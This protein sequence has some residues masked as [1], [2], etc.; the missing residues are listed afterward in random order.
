MRAPRTL[1]AALGLTLAA[2]AAK[3]Q[4]AIE[5]VAGGGPG[6]GSPALLVN[7]RTPQDVVRDAV[8]NT[9]I[10]VSDD[11]RVYRIG[12]DGNIALV[13]GSGGAG[14]SGDGGPAVKA[15]LVS[16]KGLAFDTDGSLLIA[17]EGGRRVR[18]V[19]LASGKISTLVGGGSLTGE[20][21]A[22]LQIALDA[23]RDVAVAPGGNLFLAD[24]HRVRKLDRITGLVTTV[25][26][27]GT[28]GFSD[29]SPAASRRLNEPRALAI[30]SSGA[31]LIADGGNGR[32]RKLVLGTDTISTLVSGICSPGGVAVDAA[33]VYFNSNT[34][35]CG[36][37]AQKYQKWASGSV[38]TITSTG[39]NFVAQMSV[40]AGGTLLVADRDNYRMKSVS[41]S[42]VVTNLAGN[43]TIGTYGGVPALS[44]SMLSP[45]HVRADA[46]GNIYVYD[47][48][49]QIRRVNPAGIE[50]TLASAVNCGSDPKAFLCA[51]EGLAMLPGGSL[52]ISDSK[53]DKLRKI[54]PA[55][56]VVTD[57]TTATL[58]RPRGI[59]SSASGFVY[60][61]DRGNGN[62][63]GAI[64]K[65][66]ATTGVMTVVAASLPRPQYVAVDGAD[67]VYFTS[68][69]GS[70][71]LRILAGGSSASTYVTLTS[72][73]TGL[74]ADAAGNVFASDS[75]NQVWKIA[76][77]TSSL[78]AGSGGQGLGD[79][80]SALDASLS[81]P[82]GLSVVGTDLYIA[83]ALN[84]R[85]RRVRANRAPTAAAGSDQTLEATSPSGAA[86]V[87]DGTASTD[88][89]GDALAFSWSGPFGSASGSTASITLPLGTHTIT[90]SVSDGLMSAVDTLSVTVQD[91]VGPHIS[92]VRSPLPNANGWNNSDVTL[93]FTCS[94]SG[95][96]AM[97]AGPPA[98]DV[99]A[100]EGAGQ[101][102]TFECSDAAGNH[103]SF[104][105][106]NINIDKTAP[107]AT[108]SA[109]PA[110][111]AA[112]WN[113]GD[114]TAS[115]TGA[116]ALSGLDG[117]QGNLVFTAEGAGQSTTGT[118]I[119]RAGNVSLP[120]VVGPIN[121]DK[122]T[123]TASA[124]RS[125]AA[126]AHGWNNTDVTVTFEGLDALSGIASCTSPAL[127][128]AEGAGQAASGTCVDVAGN[129]S[130]SASM[131][132][133][134]ID[135][136]APSISGERS[137]LANVHGWNN[138]DVT[139]SFGATDGL[140]G[141]DSC[142]PAVVLSSEAA[143]QSATGSCLDLAGN[144][145]SATVSDI[146]I[147]KTAPSSSATRSPAANA[148]GWNNTDVT[149]SFGSTD[150]LSGLD[151]CDPAVVLSGEAAGQSASG[152]CIDLAGNAASA[153]V[154][155]INIDKTTP[156]VSFGAAS[157]AANANG[158]NNTDV[159][160]G[161]SASDNLS[162]VD[163]TSVPSP[164]VLSS[165]GD[166]VSVSVEVTDLA[167]NTA[168][169][170]TPVV[171]IDKTAPEATGARVPLANVHG[172]NNSDVTVSVSAIDAL[173]GVESCEPDVVLSAEGASQS[174][175]LTCLDLAGNSASATV[176]DIN[177]D[178]TAPSSSATRSP[179]ANAHGWNNTDV[180]VAFEASDGLS[181]LDACDPAV[182]LSSEAAGQSATGSCLDLAGN[183]SS[184]TASEINID[185]TTP[186]LAFDPASPAAN[187]HGWNNT[188][189]S[190]SFATSD[191]LSGID[192]TSVPSPVVLSA[193][194]ASVSESVEV[195][196]LAG[197][198]ASFATPV[199]RID[200][201]APEVTGA[202]VPLANV[203]GWNNSDVTV[204]VSA[205]DALSGVE[206]CEADLTLSAEGASQSVT[207]ACTDLAG[208]SATATVSGINIDKTA[209]SVTGSPARAADK[210]GW[211]NH[212]VSVSWSGQDA[213]SGVLSCGSASS[214]AGPDSVSASVPGQCSDR[215]GNQGSGS[216]A[217]Q[218][219]AT[220]PTV[221][222]V[223]PPNGANYTLNQSVTAQYSCVDNL[224]GVDTC[225]GPVANGA[226]VAT[227][228]VGA[229]TFKVTATD[230]A[231]N[232]GSATNSY[233]IQYKFV[234]FLQPVDNLPT[235]NL[236]N[237]GR[238]IPIKWQVKDA[239]GA[240][241]SDLSSVVSLLSAP[242]A[243]DAAPVDIV[244]EETAATG[245][246]QLRY[247]GLTGQF[248]FNWSTQKGWAGTCAQIQ[249]TLADG[250]R[251]Y[252]KFKFK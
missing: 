92:V 162:G 33:G 79:G 208:N 177:I 21:I 252:A 152:S 161:F 191:N 184:A 141:L 214:Y 105:E 250:T 56:G 30:D 86:V 134:N 90:L 210:N 103:A 153:T 176:S 133:V 166:S 84:Y 71:I 216:F 251:Q 59:A 108:G 37:N 114:V 213:L 182:V 194:G 8:G 171:K 1:V 165:E 175:T 52:A 160:F 242:L 144:S 53:D 223:T 125:P 2:S 140:S 23:P 119:D 227:A 64:R 3:A 31:I 47:N 57:V 6:D 169:F 158:W 124:T 143:G 104:T 78:F 102:R 10:A 225:S 121:I 128:S 120:A 51:V 241:V 136:T 87:L 117:C 240:S 196:D 11:R 197:N 220:A 27:T 118:C 130:A 159:S 113:N 248:I 164:L 155:E 60:V 230:A 81:G 22:A 189:V 4:G 73:V 26:G 206:S 173:S 132:D 219:D 218:Y 234:G 222:I 201:T 183:S 36:G 94:D 172:W 50:G 14:T 145:S 28:A 123:P 122:T 93:A 188:D 178:K 205:I 231:G 63:N 95:S 106:S 5:T 154:S 137:P 70:A 77:G 96:G 237:A 187:P 193:E 40:L 163:G 76:A 139:V 211:Y 233:G 80:G 16:P 111:N 247:D 88:P 209:P 20:G 229:K 110:P 67:N 199:V 150:G 98:P 168:S 18:R 74:D 49:N 142:D 212:A 185:K 202:R 48:T 38:S 75:N 245:G 91:T 32:I 25:A 34:G 239:A 243:C 58:G 217:L 35:G 83:D 226:A 61:A 203:H 157:P 19:D 42:G 68:S 72:A 24:G 107:T 62:N 192:T 44:A 43:G 54:D 15:E 151:S 115:F 148:H 228:P 149:V 215:A 100:L 224:S 126:N 232:A 138:T 9:Y 12:T 195:T 236:A 109:A 170:A 46:A 13:A 238:T 66:N 55:T 204:S 167:G 101:S 112:G 99:V 131:T 186:S 135:K 207:R 180:T 85:I 45:T 235:I 129:E 65:V 249:L 69:G 146:N 174:A 181:G 39:S 17:D 147:D 89:D 221:S 29:G 127:L 97:L 7:L 244:E 200:K 156:S 82:G 116:D 190:F 246:T 198:T 179:A 41:S